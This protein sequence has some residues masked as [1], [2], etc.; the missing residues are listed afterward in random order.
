MK[1]VDCAAKPRFGAASFF[2]VPLLE[3]ITLSP[4]A[5]V[6]RSLCRSPANP[7]NQAFTGLTK[8]VCLSVVQTRGDGATLLLYLA[9][10]SKEEH[11]RQQN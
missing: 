11:E 8:K 10:A 4:G 1:T 3:K 7:C 6:P 5:I 2:G 9:A